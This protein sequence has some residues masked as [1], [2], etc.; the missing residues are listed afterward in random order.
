VF[1]LITLLYY[2]VGKVITKR[3][4]SIK[5]YSYYFSVKLHFNILDSY[6]KK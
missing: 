5:L 3:R 1:N 4:L 2:K 6:L